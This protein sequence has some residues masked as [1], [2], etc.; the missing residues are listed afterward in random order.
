MR[1]FVVATTL[2]LSAFVLVQNECRAHRFDSENPLAAPADGNNFLFI[3]D[4]NG[5]DGVFVSVNT[6]IPIVIGNTYKITAATG[7]ASDTPL[8]TSSIQMWTGSGGGTANEDFI[9]QGHAGAAPWTDA[10]EGQWVDNSFE[11]T[12]NDFALSGKEIVIL[13]TN[14]P[15]GGEPDDAVAY[16]DNFRVTENGNEVFLDGFEGV[17]LSPGG[18]VPVDDPGIGWYQGNALTAQSGVAAAG[19]PEPA[20]LSLLGLGALLLAGV[21][22]RAG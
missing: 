12:I 21:R 22:R 8:A 6:G 14:F 11:A 2:I 9:G 17:A 15:L 18:S 1:R 3:D 10:P 13:V 20:A 19:I 7:N 5:P 4:F 16:W